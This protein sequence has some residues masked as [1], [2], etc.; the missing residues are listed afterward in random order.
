VE[1]EVKLI[2]LIEHARRKLIQHLQGFVIKAELKRKLWRLLP[3]NNN[4]ISRMRKL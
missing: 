4:Q 3:N 2:P 1:S